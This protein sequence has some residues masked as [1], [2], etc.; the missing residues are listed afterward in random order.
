MHRPLEFE[1]DLQRRAYPNPCSLFISICFQVVASKY[2]V[3]A[4]L[5]RIPDCLYADLW[6]VNQY[7]KK[8]KLFA[9]LHFRDNGTVRL[10]SRSIF[11]MYIRIEGTS[12]YS[13]TRLILR[14]R[15]YRRPFSTKPL[16]TQEAQPNPISQDPNP[17]SS[18]T[19]TNH[20]RQPCLPT[21]PSGIR[22]RSH[23]K[24]Q[25]G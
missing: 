15:I 9:V 4:N 6:S 17:Q 25:N 19:H 8:P 20:P 23:G 7:M 16:V 12:L 5:N 10:S 11:Q 1:E 24:V 18:R 2:T 21:L 22:R 3:Y 13:L 14:I